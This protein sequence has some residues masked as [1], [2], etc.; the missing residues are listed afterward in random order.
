LSS[1]LI[2][3]SALS[4]D[5]SVWKARA[6]AVLRT[7]ADSRRLASSDSWPWR[8]SSCARLLFGETRAGRD[9]D[10][11]LAIG[12]LVLALTCKM[13]LASISK[14]TSTCGMPRGAGGRPSSVNRPMSC[15]HPI[16]LRLAARESPRRADCRRPW[17]RSR[18]ARG[19][20]VLASSAWSSRHPEFR[21][22]G[23]R[24]HVEQQHIFDVA[25]EN[26]ALKWPRQSP[27]LHRGLRRDALPA[28]KIRARDQ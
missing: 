24:S 10:G 27:R 9:L 15:C 6:S 14:V 11:L 13:P 1:A 8:P 26:A 19:I 25:R 12:G 20:V 28:E 2:L 22:R 7:S 21:C 5:R 3:A 17:R 23:K 4:S 16:G 18:A